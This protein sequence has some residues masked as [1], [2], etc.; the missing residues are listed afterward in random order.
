M[1]EDD[2]SSYLNI[3]ANTE[4]LGIYLAFIASI[5]RKLDDND[6]KIIVNEPED[7]LNVLAQVAEYDPA[8]VDRIFNKL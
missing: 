7:I 4:I 5:R 8:I 6:E 1:S 2:K 3:L